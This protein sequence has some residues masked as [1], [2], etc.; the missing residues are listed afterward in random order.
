MK[1]TVRR[2]LFAHTLLALALVAVL[3]S[4]L[5]SPVS[6]AH[7]ARPGSHGLTSTL[8]FNSAANAPEESGD[9]GLRSPFVAPN[10]LES[11]VQVVKSFGLR[12]K[13]LKT[14][15]GKATERGDLAKNSALQ[16]GMSLPSCVFNVRQDN[17]DP[18][19]FIL[20]AAPVI[21][22]F[23]ASQPPAPYGVFLLALPGATET[24]M[25]VRSWS[26]TEIRA[27]PGAALAAGNYAVQLRVPSSLKV[28]SMMPDCAHTSP[29]I[30]ILKPPPPAPSCSLQILSK[31]L[32]GP[33]EV[34][35][36]RPGQTLTVNLI[37]KD[38]LTEGPPVTLSCAADK[39]QGVTL[40]KQPLD[41][42]QPNQVTLPPA[43]QLPYCPGGRYVLRAGSCTGLIDIGTGGGNVCELMGN[44]LRSFRLQ[45]PSGGLPG[46][47]VVATLLTADGMRIPADNVV[48][49]PG[50]A[51]VPVRATVSV[52]W[53]VSEDEAGGSLLAEGSDYNVLSRTP[54][55]AS[56][57]FAS[58]SPLRIV[59]A[60]R[61]NLM[62]A[63][64][65]RRYLRADVRL[66]LMGPAGIVSCEPATLT[67]PLDILSQPLVPIPT[68]LALFRG[69]NFGATEPDKA[70]LIVLPAEFV[71]HDGTLIENLEQ[72]RTE[73]DWLHSTVS[74]LRSVP[75]L[76]G[77]ATSFLPGLDILREA[78][79]H[80]TDPGVHSQ[81][82]FAKEIGNL[83]AITF[84]GTGPFPL[85]AED[86]FRSL[87]FVGVPGKRAEF[88]NERFFRDIQGSFE[89]TIG[90]GG[91]AVIRVLS[92]RDEPDSFRSRA[93]P[94]VEGG[95]VRV[96]HE[97]EGQYQ[98]FE[99]SCFGIDA[100]H[101][102]NTFGCEMSSLRFLN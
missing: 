37:G 25:T 31:P 77:F 92:E 16:G 22:H 13:T 58:S 91:A 29:T 4:C 28:G 55:S 102:V 9:A 38:A 33:G 41:E 83:G 21:A 87:I 66:S 85:N 82:G 42:T 67:A 65:I 88:F 63:R 69:T 40:T 15:G 79:A 27:L 72:L 6:L 100:L 57:E 26:D 93:A 56:F 50:P 44:S 86:I 2:P 10:V 1:T 54:Q 19:V 48:M 59:E 36:A 95:M 53:S 64:P 80:T 99:T 3:L 62:S 24:S 43:D 90:P 11:R 84:P 75:S 68:V 45:A 49:L 52:N 101:H 12:D 14:L 35:H 81:F 97:P 70:V 18:N 71:A 47:P 34:P 7:D 5:L 23:G 60:T 30:S 94:A 46:V 96:T 8:R 73:L 76:A 51:G 17:D 20:T 98:T 32:P 78:L 61:D 39:N 74:S 89:L